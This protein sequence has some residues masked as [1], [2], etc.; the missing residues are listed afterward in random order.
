MITYRGIE[1][2][3]EQIKAINIL[4]PSRN[5]KKVQKLTEMAAA[6][7]RFISQSANR[8]R[9]F[10]QLL[11]TLKNFRWTEECVTTFEDLKQYLS[12]PPILSKPEKGEVLFAY[13]AV[14]DYVVSLVLIRNKDG[15][16]RPIY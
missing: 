15:I 16:Q 11:H 8:C 1:V 9:P 5:P 2:N 3:P 7:N 12:S 4:H 6:L 10:F 13:L 14:T